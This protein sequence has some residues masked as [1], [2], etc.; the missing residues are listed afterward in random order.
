[1]GLTQEPGFG[2]KNSRGIQN[3]VRASRMYAE[4]LRLESNALRRSA[5]KITASNILGDSGES[6][7]AASP[8]ITLFDRCN[9][10][11]EDDSLRLKPGV[12]ASKRVGSMTTTAN[13]YGAN[14]ADSP[15]VSGQF[16]RVA[17]TKTFYN[18][19]SL[20]L[21]DGGDYLNMA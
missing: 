20:E 15:H 13:V 18:D 4:K 12:G 14:V 16:S 21:H 11:E 8:E 9:A 3:T 19:R 5:L 17:V 6:A 2:S 7:A 10:G 1:M